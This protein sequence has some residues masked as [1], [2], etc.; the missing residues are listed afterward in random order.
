MVPAS[1]RLPYGDRVPLFDRLTALSHRHSD[2]L[3]ADFPRGDAAVLVLV[4]DQPVP[5]IV[6]TR[7]R[8]DLRTDPGFVAFPGGRI[9]AGETPEDAARRECEEEVGVDRD[10]ITAHGRLDETWNGAGFRIIPV[11]ASI[12]GP[13]DLTPQESEVSAAGVVPLRSVT[14]DAHHETV[15]AH[16]DGH[17]YHDDVIEFVD[18]GGLPWRLYGPTADLARDLAVWL[19]GEDRRRRARRQFELDQFLASRGT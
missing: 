5:G 16:V 17:D 4:V 12:I 2:R 3:E 9:D 13:I 1:P 18:D 15:I 19:R 14:A 8:V 11:V 10:R 7:R 6:L